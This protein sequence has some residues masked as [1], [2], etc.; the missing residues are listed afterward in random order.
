M[1]FELIFFGIFVW[2]FFARLKSGAKA[3]TVDGSATPADKPRWGRLAQ[4]L[5]AS[6][7]GRGDAGQ[8]APVTTVPQT[9][10]VSR[11]AVPATDIKG[12]RLP[13]SRELLKQF[14]GQ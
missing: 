8:V 12:M 10:S 3:E 1:L 6:I 4:D 11:T 5:R 7:E 9:H 14:G 2:M 13:S